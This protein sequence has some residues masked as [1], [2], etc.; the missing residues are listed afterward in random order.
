MVIYARILYVFAWI[1]MIF[2]SIFTVYGIF[3]PK[4]I[5]A[6]SDINVYG[7]LFAFFGLFVTGVLVAIFY[8]NLGEKILYDLLIFNKFNIGVFAIL[9]INILRIFFLSGPLKDEN[10]LTSTSIKLMA[11]FSL[12]L[13]LN[14]T[15]LLVIRNYLNMKN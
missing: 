10:G 1:N 3:Y 9:G 6:G 7:W 8:V 13:F 2:C 15:A 14:F 11:T 4:N 12:A 5:L